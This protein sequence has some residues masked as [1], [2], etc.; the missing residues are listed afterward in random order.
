MKRKSR[1]GPRSRPRS[2][3]H[4]P[5]RPA[6]PR[7]RSR[8]LG[9]VVER[10]RIATTHAAFASLLEAR[11]RSRVVIEA[12]TH[13]PWVS[14]AIEAYGH[15]GIVANPRHVQ[16]ISSSKNKSD[17]VDASRS[18]GWVGWIPSPPR[19]PPPPRRREL[20]FDPA[21]PRRALALPHEPDRPRAM[22]GEVGGF[23]TLLARHRQLRAS[24]ARADPRR[25]APRPASPAASDRGDHARGE[26]ARPPRGS[27]LQEDLPRDD[28]A[29]PSRR[30]RTHHVACLRAD[31]RLARAVQEE[32]FGRR[33]PRA[34]RASGQSGESDPQLRITKAGNPFLRRMLR[35]CRHYVSA[36]GPDCALR[37]FGDALAA[38]G[39]RNAKKRAVV[40]VARKPPCFSTT[41]GA[42]GRSTN[43][44][45]TPAPRRPPWRAPD[46]PTAEGFEVTPSERPPTRNRP[47]QRTRVTATGP[48]RP[49][50]TLRRPLASPISKPAPPSSRPQTCTEP[51]AQHEVDTKRTR[52]RLTS[53]DERRAATS[54]LDPD[55]PLHRRHPRRVVA[56]RRR[57]PNDAW[58][59]AAGPPRRA[60]PLLRAQ[61]AEGCGRN[62][63]SAREA[64]PRPRRRRSRSG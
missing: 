29:A 30:R 37:R 14:R 57:V 23:A 6:Q 1:S 38:R 63:A 15:E 17:R 48:Q 44:C 11:P 26:G 47:S 60:R 46:Q 34:Q 2:P 9:E 5:G 36:F 53:D 18:Q 12:S 55:L 59:K 52:G 61:P 22:R 49:P 33:L 56:T 20:T 43:P 21:R 3:W 41:S 27:A 35:E 62:V 10:L 25:G 31:S 28:V 8:R 16:L 32:P 64:R 58:R 54:A 40:A 42:A 51:T 13:S 19:D 7:L 45:A 24:G 4:R 39:G 50:E